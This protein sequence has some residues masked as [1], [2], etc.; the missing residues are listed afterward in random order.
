MEQSDTSDKVD[1]FSIDGL[2]ANES[3]YYSKFL[4]HRET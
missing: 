1:R 2:A 4:D 3:H